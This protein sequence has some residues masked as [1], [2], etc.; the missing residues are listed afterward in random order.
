LWCKKKGF[1]VSP[2]SNRKGERKDME[3]NPLSRVLTTKAMLLVGLAMLV[4]VAGLA[5]ASMAPV[6]QADAAQ[7]GKASAKEPVWRQRGYQ[8]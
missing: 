6:G 5:I 7:K 3:G 2:E 8:H 4:A 1:W